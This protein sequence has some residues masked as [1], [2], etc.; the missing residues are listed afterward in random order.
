M[1]FHFRA[2]AVTDAGMKRDANEDSMM[3]REDASLWMVADGMGGHHAGGWASGQLREALEKLELT[4]DFDLN[5]SRIDS[6]VHAA[7]AV[8]LAQSEKSGTVSGSTVAILHCCGPRFA[9]LWAGDSRVYLHR[10]GELYR[11]TTDHSEV[12]EMV[13]AGLITDEQAAR[14]PRRNILTRA[15]GVDPKLKLDA[16]VDQLEANDKFLLCSDGLSTVV[17]DEEI[18]DGLE[19]DSPEETTAQKL[20]RLTLSRGAPDNVTVIAIGCNPEG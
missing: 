16:I 11:M 5:F 4:D 14:H 9:I 1:P 18:R 19:A 17:S 10:Q 2:D 6:A 8:I 20:L 12:Q 3:L 15:V 7:N 13:E